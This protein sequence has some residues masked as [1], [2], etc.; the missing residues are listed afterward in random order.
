MKIKQSI[1]NYIHDLHDKKNKKRLKNYSPSIISSNCTGGFIYHWLGLKFRSP[2]INLY[3][4]NED[5]VNML[6]NWECTKNSEII[7]DK[8]TNKPFPVGI[9]GGQ[10]L[11]FSLCI[12]PLFLMQK[13]NGKIGWS[14]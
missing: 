12:I 11:E 6:E 9:L 10:K 4:E 14:E 2:F 3:L 1:L 13:T 7:E 8:N 5:F